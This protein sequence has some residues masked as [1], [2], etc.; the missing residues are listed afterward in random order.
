MKVPRN[1]LVSCTARNLTGSY[2]NKVQQLLDHSVS[3]VTERYAHLSAESLQEAV[4]GELL[5]HTGNQPLT[6]NPDAPDTTHQPQ[7]LVE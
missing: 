5:N 6:N 1:V 3:R 4:A 7:G 2:L